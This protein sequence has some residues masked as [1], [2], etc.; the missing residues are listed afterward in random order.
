MEPPTHAD[1]RM[2]AVAQDVY[3]PPEILELRDV[4]RPVPAD[5][6]VLV[7]VHAAGVDRGVAHLV[8]GLPYPV[9]YTHLTLPT[10]A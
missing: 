5:D 3:G 7:R 10:K 1:S 8:T 9:S 6:E 2:K 4:E